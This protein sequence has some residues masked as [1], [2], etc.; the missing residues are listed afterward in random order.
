MYPAGET[1]GGSLWSTQEGTDDC[2]EGEIIR[3]LGREHLQGCESH[4]QCSLRAAKMPFPASQTHD[5]KTHHSQG[6]GKTVQ[7]GLALEN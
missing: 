3:D 6:L 5:G 2:A 4:A 7:E 1:R